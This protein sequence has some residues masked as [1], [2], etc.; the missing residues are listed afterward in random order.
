MSA[1]AASCCSCSRAFAQH[2][3]KGLGYRARTEAPSRPW[4]GERGGGELQATVPAG[5]VRTGLLEQ[6]AGQWANWLECPP[7]DHWLGGTPAGALIHQPDSGAAAIPTRAC[8]SSRG[9]ARV[10]GCRWSGRRVGSRAPGS[11]HDV[12]GTQLSLPSVLDLSFPKSCLGAV[13]ALSP[14]CDG[15]ACLPCDGPEHTGCGC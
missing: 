2:V 7:A 15:R 3:P 4:L 12:T 6:L 11:A 10:Q 5:P 8:C 9:R 1:L 13:Y 14:S